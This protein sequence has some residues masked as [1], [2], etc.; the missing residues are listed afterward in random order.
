MSHLVHNSQNGHVTLGRRET[1]DKVQKDVGPGMMRD[2]Q[3]LKGSA[4]VMRGF[5]LVAYGTGADKFHNVLL[6]PTQVETEGLVLECPAG[7]PAPH[8]LCW[9]LPQCQ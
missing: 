3:G 1:G 2:R 9:H 4:G 8:L 7:E 6:Q 5:L